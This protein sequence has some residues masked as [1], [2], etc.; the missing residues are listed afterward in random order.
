MAGSAGA[1]HA[2]AAGGEDL[3][4]LLFT[5]GTSG[6][7]QGRDAQ[8]PGAAGQ[9]SRSAARSTR[10]RCAADDVVLL[11]LPL[12]HI[13]GLNAGLGMVAAT[14]ATG[15]LVE[16]FDAGR[17][18]RRWS[19][20]EG[21]TNV[22]G[23]PPMYVAWAALPD[24]DLD[25]ALRGVR[26]LRLRRGA[27]A[28]GR[29]RAGCRP[30]PAGT[31]YEGYG[32]TETAP[33]VTSTLASPRVEARLDRPADPGRRGAAGRRE[34]PADRRADDDPGEI[35][36]RGANLFS[37]YWPDG[38]GRA[39]T[40]TAGGPTGDVAYADDDGDLFL[41]DRRNELVLVSGFNVYPREV[42]DALAEHPDVAEVAVIAVPHPHTGEAVK[43]FVVPRA[44]RRTL[45][46]E[47]VTA[48]CADPAGPVQAPDRSSSSSPRCRTR[49]PARS[50][51]AGCASRPVRSGRVTGPARV[52]LI[53]KPGCHLCDEAREVVARVT[54]EL[55]EEYE[56]AEHPRRPRP[57]R[58]LLGA[59]PGH[60]G[61]RRS[62]TTSGGCPRTGCG[63]R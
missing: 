58:A 6:R 30:R 42:E 13:Y 43:A 55:G 44:R 59:D 32:L 36:V 37:G 48:H 61:R 8:P 33:V 60:P 39:R 63:R 27:A 38:A 62:S 1:G 4:V 31:V 15:V 23:A 47:D 7:P 19:R 12:F 9:P 34:R 10:R 57:A 14:G 52:T 54:A 24:V 51:R 28:A 46:P 3:A 18:A 17:D 45:R 25:A 35:V 29:A 5:S 40:P 2:A 11:V 26:L 16:R 21:V 22:P 50:P 49:R 56:R 41:V 20:A 53:G